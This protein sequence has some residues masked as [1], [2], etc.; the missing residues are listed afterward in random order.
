MESKYASYENKR[1]RPEEIQ[2]DYYVGK[3][4]E[5]LETHSDSDPFFIYLSFFTKFYYKFKEVNIKVD[6]PKIL[7]A[8][9]EAVGQITDLLKIA[10]LYNNTIIFF[11]SDNGGRA[12]PDGVTSPN[13]PMKEFKGSVYEGGT[14]VPSFIHSPLLDGP[15]QR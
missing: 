8:M 4:K 1:S 11:I 6:R 15:G 3:V 2:A 10:N 7:K 9:D 5:I 13:F 14:K 12:M